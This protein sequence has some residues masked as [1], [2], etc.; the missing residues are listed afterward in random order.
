MSEVIEGANANGKGHSIGWEAQ[1]WWRELQPDTQ[2]GRAPRGNP[3]ALAKLRRASSWL[4]AA[5]IPE[6]VVLFSALRTRGV[7]SFSRVAVLAAVLAHVRERSDFLV[8]GSVGKAPNEKDA[9][10][11][12]SELRL[13]RLLRVIGDDD[14]MSAFRR[15]VAIM[16]NTANVADLSEQIL[17]WDHPERGDRRRVRFAFNYWK[18]GDAAPSAPSSDR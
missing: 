1:T 4:E 12:L 14:I 6:T 15:L 17:F 5:A 16:G 7:Q 3:A 18:A 10:P 9:S 8:A 11:V 13:A 2:R